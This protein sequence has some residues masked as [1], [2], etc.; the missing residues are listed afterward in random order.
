MMKAE[1][2]ADLRHK[3]NQQ[4]ILGTLNAKDFEL[5]M[6]E[7]KELEADQSIDWLKYSPV[8]DANTKAMFDQYKP[9]QKKAE[10][11]IPASK[12]PVRR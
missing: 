6:R 5:R 4:R 12:S 1:H 3:L 2:I 9:S 8:E 7:I 11:E 10:V